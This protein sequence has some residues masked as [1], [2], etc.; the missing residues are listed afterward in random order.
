MRSLLLSAAL[1]AGLSVSTSASAD[2]W[3]VDPAHSEVGFEVTHMLIS[4]VKGSFSGF[5]GTAETDAKGALTSLQGAVKVPSVDTAN[6]KRDGHLV[7]PD[8][9]DAATYP[10]MRFASTQVKADGKGYRV[11]GDLTIRGVTK[12]VT[13]Q[14]SGLKGPVTDPWGNVKAGTTATATINRQDFGVSWSQTLYAGGAV[15]SDEVEI[16][17]AL[18]LVKSAG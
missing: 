8:F 12:P 6:E 16:E 10:E 15:V 9:F 1:L 4:T 13:F 3:T 5:E 14:V 7:S 17:L 11:T 2:R 18:Q